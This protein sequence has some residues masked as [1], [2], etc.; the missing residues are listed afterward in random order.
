MKQLPG[1]DDPDALDLEELRATLESP[2]FRRITERLAQVRD[3]A[4]KRLATVDTW[5]D[6]RYTQGVHAGVEVALDVPRILVDEI[7][8]KLAAKRGPPE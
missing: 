3:G 5:D 6:A 4:L 7:R 1:R 2:G 8:K